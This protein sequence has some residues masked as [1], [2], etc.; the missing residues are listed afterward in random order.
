MFD[1]IHATLPPLTRMLI[2]FSSFL[3]HD[4]IYVVILGAV[5]LFLFFR[6]MPERPL[7]GP[8]EAEAR[9]AEQPGE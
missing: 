8:G 1:S 3:R 6:A 5:G 2:A 9:L 4:G 7:K